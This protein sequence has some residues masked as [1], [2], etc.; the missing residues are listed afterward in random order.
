VDKAY[1]SALIL[2]CLLYSRKR[3]Q[4][5]V[6]PK[7]EMLADFFTK[8]LQGSLIAKCCDLIINS[9]VDPQNEI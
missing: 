8:P 6:S 2:N 3:G 4:N 1:Q 7:H 9:V 5:E